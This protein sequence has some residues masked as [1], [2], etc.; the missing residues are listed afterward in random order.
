MPVNIPYEP[1]APN[2]GGVSQDLYPGTSI[3]QLDA[4]V[5]WLMNYDR[6]T[7]RQISIQD[8]VPPPAPAEAQAGAGPQP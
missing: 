3:V 4:V 7:G 1:D 5:D 6:F 8:R 2:L